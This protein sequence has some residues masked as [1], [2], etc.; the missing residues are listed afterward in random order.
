MEKRRED[1]STDTA[2]SLNVL[3]QFVKIVVR[4]K[5]KT[6]KEKSSHWEI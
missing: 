3:G 4:N 2:R 1:K 6:V 5:R